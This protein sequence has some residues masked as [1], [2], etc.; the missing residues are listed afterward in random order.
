MGLLIG[1]KNELSLEQRRRLDALRPD[2][3]A[4]LLELP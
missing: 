1:I 4:A 3:S 2:E